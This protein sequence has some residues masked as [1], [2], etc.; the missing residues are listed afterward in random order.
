[1]PYAGHENKGYCHSC[2]ETFSPELP[3][4]EQRNTAQPKTHNRSDRQPVAVRQKP[5]SFIPVEVFKG[6]LKA[7]ETNHFVKFLI[8]L[9]GV[10]VAHE[11]VSRYF[12][13]TSK[14]WNGAAVFWQIDARGKIRAGKIML[15]NPT[16]G[17][18]VKEPFNHIYWAHTALKQQ[19]F[20]LNQCLFGEHLLGLPENKQKTVAVFE[21]EKSAAVGSVYLPQFICVA[22]GGK[23][24]LN[25]EKCSILKGRN[26]TLFPD[27]SKPEEGELTAFELW[28]SK[29]KEFSH[30]ANFTVSDLLERKATEQERKE[31]LDFADYL[32]RFDYKEFALQKP[33]IVAPT[34]DGVAFHDPIPKPAVVEPTQSNCLKNEGVEAEHS[35]KGVAF[36][37]TP[38]K[39]EPTQPKDG[40]PCGKDIEALENYFAALPLPKVIQLDSFVTITNV[41][42]FLKE[43]FRILRG[44][45]SSKNAQPHFERLQ[46]LKQLSEQ[47]SFDWSN[48]Q[49]FDFCSVAPKQRV[50]HQSEYMES[51]FDWNDLPPL[52]FRSDADFCPARWASREGIGIDSIVPS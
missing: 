38:V 1:M 44:K 12:I 50:V 21:S 42:V 15:Y 40:V 43:H 48:P 14:H 45:D 3:N 5:V 16:T 19:G 6:S 31:G 10:E 51:D 46:T 13:G 9:F 30:L 27:L 25:A 41:Q 26:V 20:E 8:D 29:A 52:D 2:G 4:V 17:K 37:D 36:H 33:A 34:K 22:A 32:M 11:V 24:G 49:P 18:R 39:A 47:S 35:G 7:H 28:S 23:N